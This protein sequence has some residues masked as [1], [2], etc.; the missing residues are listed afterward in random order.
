L[1][2]SI[3]AIDSA[4]QQSTH[5]SGDASM[6]RGR[7][8]DVPQV[9]IRY[10]HGKYIGVRTDRLFEPEY[11][12]VCSPELFKRRIPLNKP[13][14]LR[15]FALIHDETIPDRALRPRWEAW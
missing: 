8:R 5:H 2:G 3:K 9:W 7:N 1:R 14:D 13:E 6:R 11:T 15:H 4:A 12:A 10:G